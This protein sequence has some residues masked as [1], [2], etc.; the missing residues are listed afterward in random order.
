MSPVR[1]LLAAMVLGTAFAVTPCTAQQNSAPLDSTKVATIHRLLD[2]TKAPVMMATG[3]ETGLA[4]QR[5]N[6]PNVPASFWDAVAARARASIPQL[7]DS[8]VPIY[9]RH[10]S[11]QELEQ[12]VQFYSTPVGQHLIEVQPLIAKESMEAGARWG[13]IIGQQVADSI[14]KARNP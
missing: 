14:T 12:L 3:F 5:A 9:A 8:L 7:V 4:L 2:L 6:L 1:S 13:K 10:M 11:Q